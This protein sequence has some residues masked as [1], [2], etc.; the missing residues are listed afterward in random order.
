M[1]PSPDDPPLPPP[2][3][4]QFSTI[5]K[6]YDSSLTPLLLSGSICLYFSSAFMQLLPD[7]VILQ[8]V[9]LII[10]VCRY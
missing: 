10:V 7:I 1:S 9:D 8:Q 5:V 6:P 4:V 3:F 2:P